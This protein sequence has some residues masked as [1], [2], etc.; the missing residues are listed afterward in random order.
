[1]LEAGVTIL[2]LRVKSLAPVDFLALAKLA[3]AATQAHNCKLIVNDRIDIALACDADGVHL[4][5]EDLPLSA[6]TKTHGTEDC[7]NLDP[8]SSNRPRKPSET[9]PTTSA[10]VPCSA[11]RRKVPA[12]PR[13]A[14]KCSSK[15]ARGKTTDRR[16]RRHHRRKRPTSLARRCRLGG[17]H[18][19]HPSCRRH[20]EQSDAHSSATTSQPTAIA[21][22]RASR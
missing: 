2:Q 11:R 1:M 21:L 3:R 6:A 4:G 8:R 12:T 17:D 9:A 14:S 5:Q 7:R 15:F 20:S 13:A 10:S 16:H 19:R 22:L 18:Q